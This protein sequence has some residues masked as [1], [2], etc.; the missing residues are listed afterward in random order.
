MTVP[1]VILALFAVGAGFVGTPWA[2]LFHHFLEPSG[3]VGAA[4]LG[5]MAAATLLPV[6]GI[7]A[8]WALYGARRFKAGDKDPL[9]G[10]P[11]YQALAKRWYWDE[12]YAATV[13]KLMH[14]A[15]WIADLIDALLSAL[16]DAL[17][18]LARLVAALS[19]RFDAHGIMNGA[20]VVGFTT[21]A[22]GLGF[23]KL[24]TGRT[25]H[26]VAGAALG[27]AVLVLMLAWMMWR[28][29]A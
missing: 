11:G 5:F 26:Y 7:G 21:R 23:S 2:N 1:L 16:L 24:Q 29:G 25:Q 19:R 15:A 4:D 12:I 3:H 14:A 18:A 13:V 20:R 27:A 28:A 22:A 10:M 6:V 17:A 8:G 9:A